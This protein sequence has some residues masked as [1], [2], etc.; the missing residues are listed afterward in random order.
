M[1]ILIRHLNS[2]FHKP[3]RAFLK[4][5]KDILEL[6]RNDKA[7]DK[8]IKTLINKMHS[9]YVSGP[10]NDIP[11][12]RKELEEL[13]FIQHLNQNQLNQ[14]R[15]FLVASL[16]AA[17]A[18]TTALMQNIDSPFKTRIAFELD[19]QTLT[20][21]LSDTFEQALLLPIHG[22]IVEVSS[23]EQDSIKVTSQLPNNKWLNATDAR[24]VFDVASDGDSIG[25]MSRITAYK[26]ATLEF[27]RQANDL[28]IKLKSGSAYSEM[29]LKQNFTL[30]VANKAPLDYL[31]VDQKYHVAQRIQLKW[32][33]ENHGRLRFKPNWAVFSLYPIDI[34]ALSFSSESNNKKGSY[35]CLIHSGELRVI[36]YG[37]VERIN[38]GDCLSL[39]AL[40]GTIA[41]Y[42][43]AKGLSVRFSGTVQSLSLGS[44]KNQ[45]N[46]T[47]SL[48]DWVLQQPLF[49]LLASISGPLITAL[50]INLFIRT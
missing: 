16:L 28:F 44:K 35:D 10:R 50:V 38:A 4:Y 22:E 30:I 2:L 29:A 31:D 15:V 3:M 37:Q 12:N 13:Q 18:F 14:V 40:N 20:L 27:E 7:I 24:L 46:I 26:E 6:C 32:T 49:Y 33:A 11:K 36:D 21:Q 42:E 23:A 25:T 1:S 34:S 19:T 5:I 48:L 41:I 39:G 17:G 8:E 43:G 45:I 9:Q 47:P